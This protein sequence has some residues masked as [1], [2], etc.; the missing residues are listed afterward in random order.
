MVAKPK[1]QRPQGPEDPKAKPRQ[2]KRATEQ[3]ES[4]PQK[5]S[6]RAKIIGFPKV[7]LTW[8][9]INKEKGGRVG[10]DFLKG[11]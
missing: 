6:D 10:G 3:R 11:K 5:E 9:I 7:V 1:T 2:K 8:L 4:K